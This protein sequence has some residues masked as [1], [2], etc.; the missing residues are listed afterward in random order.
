MNVAFFLTPKSEVACIPMD[1]TMREALETMKYHQYT[2]VPL[3]EEDGSY[4]GT[5]TEGDLLWEINRRDVFSIRDLER[6]PLSEVRRNLQHQAVSIYEDVQSLLSLALDQN[7]VP[8]VDDKGV[9]IGIVT[10]KTVIEF[11]ATEYLQ[12]HPLGGMSPAAHNGDC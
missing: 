6:I 8:V 5:L 12:K 3:I 1:S 9:F 10:R 11:F 2:A 4:V 7:F